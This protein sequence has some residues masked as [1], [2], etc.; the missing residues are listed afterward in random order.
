[1]PA[2]TAREK[3]CQTAR[4]LSLKYSNPTFV[5]LV[6]PPC[7]PES[8]S[9][10]Q[11]RTIP[12][13]RRPL[14]QNMLRPA[15]AKSLLQAHEPTRGETIPPVRNALRYTKR[16]TGFLARYR[17]P[18]HPDMQGYRFISLAVLFAVPGPSR[19]VES[20]NAHLCGLVVFFLLTAMVFFFVVCLIGKFSY[21]LAGVNYER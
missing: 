2:A 5:S 20:I 1:M 17:N 12:P 14:L 16:D 8:L 10:A 9:Y 13:A 18:I 4:I 21:L 3:K 6:N 19:R 15:E 11:T 7:C